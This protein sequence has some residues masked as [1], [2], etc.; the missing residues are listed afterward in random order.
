MF[1]VFLERYEQLVCVCKRNRPPHEAIPTT[2]WERQKCAEQERRMRAVVMKL[3]GMLLN[4]PEHKDARRLMDQ[5][6]WEGR[7]CEL[8]LD[9]AHHAL[10]SVIGRAGVNVF[11]G[12]L[13]PAPVTSRL[14]GTLVQ[15]V[16]R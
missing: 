4:G 8:M 3:G 11:L 16:V 7:E 9:E 12:E 2:S 6:G 1:E 15:R 14:L 10:C 13:I 5:H